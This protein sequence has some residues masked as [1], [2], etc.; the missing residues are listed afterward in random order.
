MTQCKDIIADLYEDIRQIDVLTQGLLDQIYQIFWL[1]IQACLNQFAVN[2]IVIVP[3]GDFFFIPFQALSYKDNDG[4]QILTTA[5]FDL[6]YAIGAARSVDPR[7][8]IPQHSMLRALLILSSQ[9]VPAMARERERHLNAS[10]GIC[11]Y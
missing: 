3:H 7:L 2:S 9:D 6:M 4:N 5:K 8:W 11:P 1:P 10:L